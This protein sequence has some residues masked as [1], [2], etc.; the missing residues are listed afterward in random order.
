MLMRNVLTIETITLRHI[1]NLKTQRALS[2]IL[3][4]LWNHQQEE[5]IN[6]MPIM[7]K[8]LHFMGRKFRGYKLLHF[9]EYFGRSRKFIHAK[10]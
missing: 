10:S 3:S 5:Q 6:S 7:L 8:I 1:R 4:E 9:H 2:S